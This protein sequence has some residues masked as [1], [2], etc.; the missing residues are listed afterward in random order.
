[1]AEDM[2]PASEF[3]DDIWESWLPL[4]YSDASSTFYT[5]LDLDTTMNTHATS[6]EELRQEC[7]TSASVIEG[8][9]VAETAR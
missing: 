9:S 5:G 3:Y 2:I 8:H 7:Y 4:L 1:M 6:N